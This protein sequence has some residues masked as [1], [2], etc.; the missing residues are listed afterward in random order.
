MPAPWRS[1]IAV[2]FAWLGVIAACHDDAN[3]DGS[4]PAQQ[5]SSVD[6]ASGPKPAPQPLADASNGDDV[7]EGPKAEMHFIGRFDNRDP[8]GPRFSWAGSRIRT[9][10]DGTGVAIK[11]SEISGNGDPDRLDVSIDGAPSTLLVTTSGITTY[12]LASGLSDGEHDLEITKRTEPSVGTLQLLALES[13]E[14]R[15]LV[16]TSA[17]A[18]RFI[19]FIGDSIT[20]GYGVLGTSPCT[21]TAS[22]E[23]ESVAYGAR[24]AAALDADHAAISWS[25]IGVWRDYSGSTVDQMPTRFLRTLPADSTSVWDFEYVPDVVVVNL[26]TNDFA[27]SDP[28]ASYQ[29]AMTNFVTLLRSKYPSA[30]IILTVSSMMAG[31]HRASERALLQAVIAARAQAGD[32]N[33]SFFEFDQQLDADGY[34]CDYHPNVTTQQKGATKLADYIRSITG[35]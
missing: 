21:F 6:D 4:P 25:G 18:K 19:E 17:P 26:G 32:S 15:P 24:T 2:T 29:T 7:D 30:P 23:D 5:S 34:G 11:L 35:W 22:T 31:D 3:S 1:P 12:P 10:F 13:T 14:K 8:L 33:V 16:P 28:G 9:R 20:C 27:K